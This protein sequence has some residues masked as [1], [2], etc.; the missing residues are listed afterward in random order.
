MVFLR[1]LFFLLFVFSK[2]LLIIS[3]HFH[4]SREID[5]FLSRSEPTVSSFLKVSITELIRTL[6]VGL[7]PKRTW[8]ASSW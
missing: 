2:M 4:F 8:M 1:F 7:S 6:G 3:F 5:Q